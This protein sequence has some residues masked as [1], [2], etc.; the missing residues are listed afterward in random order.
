M[1]IWWW[2]WGYDRDTEDMIWYGY[3]GGSTFFIIQTNLE[4]S[5]SYNFWT[6][7]E[8]WNDHLKKIII[9]IISHEKSVI[10]L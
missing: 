1:H 7:I 8:D 9:Q 2:H 10:F 6:F 5:W 3:N 4:L